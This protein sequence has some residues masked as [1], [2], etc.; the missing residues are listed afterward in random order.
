VVRPCVP[1]QESCSEAQLTTQWSSPA[2]TPVPSESASAAPPA[3]RDLPAELSGWPSCTL[4]EAQL[5]DLELIT[6]G[7]F[8]PLRGFMDEAA[9]ASVAVRGTLADGTPWPVPV[10][11]DVAAAVPADASHLV[12]QDLEGSPLAVLAITER[13]AMP[14]GDPDLG[15]PGHGATRARARAVPQAAPAP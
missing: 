14:G 3:E 10:T 2:S 4:G 7:A 5:G 1:R 9:T 12:L 6:S 15:R 13:L 11:L 8:A